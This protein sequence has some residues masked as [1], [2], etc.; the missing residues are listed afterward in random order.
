[1]RNFITPG[2]PNDVSCRVD[3]DLDG[4][5]D[6]SEKDSSSTFAGLPLYSWGARQGQMDLF[7]EVDYMDSSN[8][9]IIPRRESMQKV[10]D[11]FAAKGIHLHIDVGDLFHNTE[12]LSPSDM[13]LGGGNSI[14]FKETTSFDS[15][16]AISIYDFK[17]E[18]LA[19]ARRLIF[20]YAVFANSLLNNGGWGL[21]EVSGNDFFLAMGKANLTS[22]TTA[23]KNNLINLQAAGFLHE[24]GHNLGLR[25]GGDN[26]T[27]YKPNYMSTMNYLYQNLGLPSMGVNEA[28]R[29]H[30][31]QF[32]L[33]VT[34]CPNSYSDGATS[35][36]FKIG[37]SSG[38]GG[39][40][41][42]SQISESA[43]FKQ[44]SSTAID[45]NC[46]G[47]TNEQLSLDVN[48]SGAI[49]TSLH[50][51]NDWGNIKSYFANTSAVMKNWSIS[52]K[53]NELKEWQP[54]LRHDRQEVASEQPAPLIL[55]AE[56][57]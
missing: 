20:H 42:E 36:D 38:S 27:L 3:A 28:S 57:K 37:F 16:A 6:C 26:D 11:V 4:I 55:R 48:N 9:G 47:S 39:I 8:E 32:D 29:Y 43:G 23:N 56:S 49:D 18:N 34:I 44:P 46:N 45:F 15:S 24:F 2:G 51:Y 54:Q 12:G 22:D 1:M 17:R 52:G 31:N 33:G 14:P 25:H 53:R 13:D 21:G 5:P 30:K 41:D 35:S 7:I 40:L 50:D 10:I 19:L